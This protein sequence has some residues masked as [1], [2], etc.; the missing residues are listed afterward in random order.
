MES[1]PRRVCG[2]L[3]WRLIVFL[4]LPVFRRMRSRRRLSCL[5]IRARTRDHDP[6][7]PS[8][9]ESVTEAAAIVHDLF[10]PSSHVAPALPA[11]PPGSSP[12]TSRLHPRT[13]PSCA[14]RCASGDPIGW[15]ESF[16]SRGAQKN[17]SVAL[18]GKKHR[19]NEEFIRS[20]QRR[21]DHRTNGQH[22]FSSG[23]CLTV[24]TWRLASRCCSSPPVQQGDGSSQ[25]AGR[26]RASS[27]PGRQRARP[28]RR[29]ASVVESLGGH[30]VITYTR[31]GLKI[32][33][34]YFHVK[35]KYFPY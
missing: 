30:S 17:D 31:S 33:R 10:D 6:G 23:R 20:D 19:R 2:S 5:Q 29:R 13:A 34:Y 24:S 21:G 28:T 1:T 12:S 9:G 16:L 22:V 4:D 32:V 15:V 25:K 8:K 26:L 27:R 11:D 14:A 35:Y 7:C 18:P 3:N